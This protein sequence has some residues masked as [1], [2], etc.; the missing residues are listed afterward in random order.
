[1]FRSSQRKGL[2]SIPAGTAMPASNAAMIAAASVW[3]K[4][5]AAAKNLPKLI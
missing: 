5:P 1:M 4:N 3:V 2:K